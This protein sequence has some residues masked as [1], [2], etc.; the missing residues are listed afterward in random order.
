MKK[1]QFMGTYVMILVVGIAIGA[2][3]LVYAATQGYLSFL[4]P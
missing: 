2:G 4:L 1:G 3:L